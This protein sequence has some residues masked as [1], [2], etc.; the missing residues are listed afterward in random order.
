M[1]SVHRHR[2]ITVR[3]LS[4]HHFRIA[5]GLAVSGLPYPDVQQLAPRAFGLT[6]RSGRPAAFHI[7][8]D[9]P[10]GGHGAAQL[11]IGATLVDAGDSSEARGI[12]IQLVESFPVWCDIVWAIG[13]GA[14]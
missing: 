6:L 12:A 2:P 7:A 14:R 5:M 4:S 13:K 9:E 1:D 3:A 8:V 10:H 11:T